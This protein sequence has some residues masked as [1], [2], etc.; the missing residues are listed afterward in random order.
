MARKVRI[1]AI[2]SVVATVLV[3]ALLGGAYYA[4]QQV[5]PF[6]EQALKIEP[7]VLERGSRELESRATALYSDAK[8]IGHWHGVVYGRANQ[9][10][11][12]DAAGAG[13]RGGVAEEYS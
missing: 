7:E 13:H 12:G 5:R 4:A 8:Q 10:L 9:R 11:A 6:Y 1:A 3:V 2:C